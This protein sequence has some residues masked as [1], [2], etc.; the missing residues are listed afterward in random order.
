MIELVEHHVN[1]VGQLGFAASNHMMVAP[2]LAD[3]FL[4]FGIYPTID[5]S[6]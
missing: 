4:M 2:M 1:H 5:S 6:K 3:W